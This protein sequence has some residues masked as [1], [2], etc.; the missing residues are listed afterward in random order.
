MSRPGDDY[1]N[2]PQALVLLG[3]VRDALSSLE[4][5][6]PDLERAKSRLKAALHYHEQL[7]ADYLEMCGGKAD[8]SRCP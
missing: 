2:C 3:G 8:E 6:T 4:G 1:C 7:R 5:P